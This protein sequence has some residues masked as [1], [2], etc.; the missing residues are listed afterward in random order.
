MSDILDGYSEKDRLSA[1][2]RR[3]YR[4]RYSDV[5]R[6]DR[7]KLWKS[8][9]SL[10]GV[11]S[12]GCNEGSIAFYS[13]GSKAKYVKEDDAVKFLDEYISTRINANGTTKSPI[14]ERDRVQ[15]YVKFGF[16]ARLLGV[17]ALLKVLN[18]IAD[19]ESRQLERL[20]ELNEYWKPSARGDTNKR[21][22]TRADP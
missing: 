2:A 15:P 4:T 21:S 13:R 6:P 22:V 17:P 9:Q 12:R 14:E 11:L 16:I 3:L 1:V 20:D 19:I 7:T 8:S 18:H 5:R 10:A